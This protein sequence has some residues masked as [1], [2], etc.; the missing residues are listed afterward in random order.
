MSFLIHCN[1]YEPNLLFASVYD[2]IL[3]LFCDIVL[4]LHKLLTPKSDWSVYKK[5][6]DALCDGKW[7]SSHFFELHSKPTSFF[8]I[9]SIHSIFWIWLDR[10]ILKWFDNIKFSW[11]A[12]CT[13]E[14]KCHPV[15]VY[16][17]VIVGIFDSHCTDSK[18]L[19]LY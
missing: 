12:N 16:V 14:A 9:H 19:F 4:P 1:L 15:C 7:F 2:M 10:M 11:C 18:W 8:S 5:R 3:W 13:S 17:V 6:N